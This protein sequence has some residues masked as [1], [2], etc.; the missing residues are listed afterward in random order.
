MPTP[1]DD[2]NIALVRAARAH[3]TATGALLAKLGLHPG[4]DALLAALWAEDGQTQSQLA[5]TLH[6][7]PPTVTKMLQ[8]MEASGLVARKA[9]KKDARAVRVRLT[10][11]GKRLQPKVEAVI[12]DLTAR[13]TEGISERNVATLRKAL[14]QIA[15]NL[16]P[17]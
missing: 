7:E 13:A 12:A 16:D 8:R 10:A 4:Q 11:K 9:D 3:R 1:Q 5:T 2:L 14:E 6:V 15:A 17:S